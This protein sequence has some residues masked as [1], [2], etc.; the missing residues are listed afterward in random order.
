[1]VS[2]CF[3]LT[4]FRFPLSCC[5]TI[6]AWTSQRACIRTG[7]GL[8]KGFLTVTA[9]FV[10]ATSANAVPS[11]VTSDEVTSAAVQPQGDIDSS[12]VITIWNTGEG[13]PV[14]DIQ[15]LTQTP[16]GYLWL[17]TYNGLVRFDGVR[18]DTFLTVPTGSRYGARIGPL[19]SDDRGRLWLA[20]DQAALLR[21]DPAGFTEFVT[22]QTN[23]RDRAVSLCSDGTNAMLWVDARGGL[24]RFN[25]DNPERVERIKGAASNASRWIRDGKGRLWLANARNVKLYQ[26]GK[27]KEAAVPGTATLTAAPCKAGGLWIARDAKLRYVNEDG[28]DKEVATFP[29]RGQSRVKCIMEDSVGRLWIGT[30]GQGLFCYVAGEFKHVLPEGNTISCLLNDSEDNIW[31]GTRGGGLIRVR[32]RHFFIH[33]SSDGLAHEFVRS[34]AQDNKGR[35]WL[36]SAEGKIGWWQDGT[37]HQLGPTEG[38]QGFEGACVMPANDGSVWVSTTHRGVWRWGNRKFYKQNFGGKEL[39]G[40]AVDMLQDSKER[41]WMVTDNSG[42]F[43]WSNSELVRYSTAEGLPSDRIRQIVEDSAGILWAGD[44]EGGIARLEGD[45]WKVVRRHSGHMDAVRTMVANTNALWIGTS[46]GGLLRFKDGETTRITVEQGL[47]DPCIQQLILDERG[48]LWGGTPHKLF[49]ISLKELDAVADRQAPRLNA[50]VYGRSDGVPDVSFANWCDPRCWRTREGELWFATASGALHFQPGNLPE[51][52]APKILLEQTLLDGKPQIAADLQNL[53]PGPG[54]LEFRFT[55]PCLTAP[56]RVRFRYQLT[57]VDRDWV[58]AERTRSAIY[59]SVPAGKYTFR[60]QASSPEGV[61]NSET[62]T[63]TLAIHPYFWQTNWFLAAIAATVAG[64]GVWTARRTAMQRLR[65][66][67]ELVRQEHAVDRE[68]ARIAQDIHD[69]LGANLTS[70]GLLAD[71][72][73]RHKSDPSA[74]SRELEQISQTARESVAAMDAIVWALNPRNDSL[75]HFA[76]YIS[77]FTRDFFRPTNVR[78]RLE[79]PA[80]L[81][82]QPLPM[83]TR[84]QLFLIVKECFNNVV[85]HAHASEVK[86]ELHCEE[87]RL[88]LMVADNGRGLSSNTVREGRNGLGNLHERIQRL[89]GSLQIESERG[90][91]TTLRFTLP[92]DRRETQ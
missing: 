19:A 86:L 51:S 29:W 80:N 53:R 81:P 69:E 73:T 57:G 37:W 10:V 30:V 28:R 68:R 26:N 47:P 87:G 36:V 2:S 64:G 39:P 41:V 85:R 61:W 78:T 75:D 66:R 44:W 50:V 77:Q 12:F 56:E 65:R 52:A 62:A 24:G 63:V 3:E 40:A 21:R 83:E 16:D 76:N 84:H 70:I 42:I 32:Q 1:M 8:K 34:L 90:R 5:Q 45:R 49:R 4:S 79:V 6:I 46:A 74:V 22:N 55:A 59:A 9:A 31:A 13:L 48:F 20:P 92:L 58:D 27:W 43:C 88:R 60:V 14:N 89:G 33:D 38:W 54:R 15:E 17:G 11:T 35:V 82:S 71:M 25:T 7:E 67:L 72:G 18:F 23:L 91:G